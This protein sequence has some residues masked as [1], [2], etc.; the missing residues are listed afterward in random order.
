M[1]RFERQWVSKLVPA[2]PRLLTTLLV[3]VAVV[4]SA[5]LGYDASVMNGLSILPS[6]TEYFHLNDATTGLNNAAVWMGSILG[7][8]VVQPIPDKFGRK[9]GILV[10][11]IITVIGIVLQ[12]AAQNIAMFVIARMII[13]FGTIL[14][15]VSA[16][17][18]LA[19]L[20]PPKSRSYV[21][22]IFFSC[23]YVGGLLSAIINYG[24]Q[25]IQSTWSWRLPSL[26][27]F[28]PSLI[29]IAFLPFIP[30]SPRW[31]IANNQEEH[32]VEVL[33][34]LSGDDS[35]DIL[36]HATESMKDIKTI[37]A[38]EEAAYPKNP[39][40][41]FISTPA[42]R[43]RLSIL[44]IF[45]A[46]LET[47]GNFIV[48]YYLTRILSQAGVTDP[49]RQNQINVIIQCWSFIIAV[50]GSFM[51]DIIGRRIQT[52]VGTAGMALMLYLL[53]GLIKAYGDSTDPAKNYGIIA[54]IFLFQGFYAFSI[55]PMTSLYPTEICQY[56]LRAAG[57]VIFRLIDNS[58]GLAASFSL[59]FAMSDLG[60]K[61]YLMNASWN[62]VFAVLVYFF[63]IETKGLQLEEIAVKFG[64]D[65]G[66]D[67]TGGSSTDI[68]KANV[69]V[70]A[71][72]KD[73]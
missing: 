61:F 52:L 10:A 65:L 64:D 22:G 28:I 31:L 26:L 63:F 60:W 66:L 7:L 4:N 73:I 16:P 68:G 72:A 47:M 13:G 20:L 8:A 12:A 33:A 44:I 59:S 5:T 43:K 36:Q 21:L 40:R 15:N 50:I 55:T 35:E 39:W 27:Q 70:E 2:N 18:L 56:K 9:N 41:E 62:L 53:G 11:T 48:S 67:S 45:G 54:V 58:L 42:N 69:H 71:T 51:L 25:N 46:M 37:I 17:P 38:R 3:A 6:Y 34:I 14:S 24:S 1:Y 57:S 49:N 30:E 19:E 23:F 29:A 32:A